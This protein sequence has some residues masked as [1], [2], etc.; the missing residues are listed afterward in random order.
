MTTRSQRWRRPSRRRLAWGLLLGA[1]AL[2]AA[3][4]V[5]VHVWRRGSRRVCDERGAGDFPPCPLGT[6]GP[7]MRILPPPPPPPSRHVEPVP[8]WVRVLST[9]GEKEFTL[10]PDAT[11]RPLTP[12]EKKFL[13][14]YLPAAVGIGGFSQGDALARI[15]VSAR[16]RL[17]EIE[18][19]LGRPMS[20]REGSHIP[21]R[22]GRRIVTFRDYNAPALVIDLDEAGRCVY[23]EAR[24]SEGGGPYLANEEDLNRLRQIWKEDMER[25][26][27]RF[28][29]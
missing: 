8:G 10:L 24:Q 1:V 15:L 11:E 26:P 13:E 27:S 28:G 25:A 14:G 19:Y 12:D 18:R 21:G 2:S 23:A 22:R 4:C 9:W 7:P 29:R 17:P 20:I 6:S 5:A 16:L 3:L